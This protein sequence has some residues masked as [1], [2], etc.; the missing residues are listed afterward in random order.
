MYIIDVAVGVIIGDVGGV[1]NVGNVDD[2]TVACASLIPMVSACFVM[3][4]CCLCCCCC[5]FN[6]LI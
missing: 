4:G 2:G 1:C 3:L 5:G 6:L